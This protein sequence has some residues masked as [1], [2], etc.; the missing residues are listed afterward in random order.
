LKHTARILI[1]AREFLHGRLTGIG[2]VLAGL[3]R[4]L[5]ECPSGGEVVLALNHADAVPATLKTQQRIT[6]FEVPESFIEAE[7]TL[8]QMSRN[9]DV[10]IS[11]Y[12]KLP[13]FGTHCPSA[14]MIHDVLDLTHPAYKKRL[15]RLFDGWRL[16]LALKRA[17]LTWY[18]SRW[19]LKETKRYAGFP[20][21]NPRVRYPGIDERFNPEGQQDKVFSEK[22]GLQPG[23]ILALGNGLPH[24]NLGLLLEIVEKFP[25]PFV[26]AGASEKNQRFWRSRYPDADPVWI[27]HVDDKD[28]P[29]L[30]RGAFCLVQPSTIEGYGYPPLE[31]MACGT[32]AV[33][34]N[35]PVLVETT[36]GNALIA[37]PEDPDAWLQAFRD[38]E[39]ES[40]YQKQKEKG[41]KWIEPLQGPKG[42]QG[43]VSDIEI[44]LKQKEIR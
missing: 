25:R 15:K 28:L 34:S 7:K 30:L 27:S 20:G 39:K 35:I 21:R 10:Y 9:F 12:P 33:V 22:Y 14:H 5:A 6:V 32:P 43:Y 36:G 44:L 31:A 42:W 8:S 24:K 40:F 18:D 37:D 41:W 3:G 23:Y 17:D 26:L 4:A 38:L 13:L 2:R 29:A 11:P 1:D 19:S 16:K